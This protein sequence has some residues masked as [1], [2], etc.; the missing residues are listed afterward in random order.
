MEKY[1]EATWM[2]RGFLLNWLN[3]ILVK[4]HQGLQYK[5]WIMRNLIRCQVWGILPK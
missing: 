4:D 1:Q 2:L 5:W 3:R